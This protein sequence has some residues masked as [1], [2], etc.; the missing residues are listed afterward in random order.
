MKYFFYQIK[1]KH[2]MKKTILATLCMSAVLTFG[3]GCKNKKP[4]STAET[5]TVE[6]V[7]TPPPTT[8]IPSTDNNISL[9][10][11]D[12]LA[13]SKKTEAA[14][15]AKTAKAEKAAAAKAALAAKNAAAAK[16][17][18]DKAKADKTKS[19]T[20][21]IPATTKGNTPTK[22]PTKGG[23]PMPT[24]P[25]KGDEFPNDQV[26]KRNGKDDV[27]RLAEAAPLYNGGDK[28]M[29]RFLQNNIKYPTKPKE[30][31]VQGT[32][33]VRFVV[34]KSGVVDDVVVAKGV[35]PMLDAEAKRVVS[36]MPKW[37]P[38][39]QK[40]KNVAVQYTLPVRFEI[41]D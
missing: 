6:A 30:D 1:N 25:K 37:T 5:N 17:K 35:H 19:A 13:N 11:A 29:R 8:E 7:P 14:N 2:N 28:A 9:V 40:N 34:E 27:L 24:P 16:A 22:A 3:T 15:A 26:I 10:N 32:V 12:S 20:T 31:G 41:A 36:I 33:F 23:K 38:G 4:N 21:K 39:R 18:A